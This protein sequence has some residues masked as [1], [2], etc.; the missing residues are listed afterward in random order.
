MQAERRQLVGM[1]AGLERVDRERQAR[2]QGE[3]GEERA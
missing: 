1:R 3:K 2:H